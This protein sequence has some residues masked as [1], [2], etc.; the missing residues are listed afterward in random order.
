[1]PGGS[2]QL[3]EELVIC[4]VLHLGDPDKKAVHLV[5]KVWRD[6]VRLTTKRLAPKKLDT[7]RI[8]EVGQPQQLHL[9]H[10]RL[11]VW[12]AV[13]HQHQC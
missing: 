10:T 9:L 13:V 2:A 11:T 12:P 5:S 4:I 3:T 7:G 6:A 8:K 1:V